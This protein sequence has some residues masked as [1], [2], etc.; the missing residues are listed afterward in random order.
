MYCIY[1]MYIGDQIE[2]LF[3]I[4]K[5]LVNQFFRGTV[6]RITDTNFSIKYDNG[7]IETHPRN[8]VWRHV[9]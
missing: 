4:E 1:K 7:F 8:I 6:L 3:K 9:L 2:V 5:T